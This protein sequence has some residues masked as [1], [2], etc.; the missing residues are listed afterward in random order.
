MDYRILGSLEVCDGDRSVALG[1]DKQRALLAILL[2][3][4]NEA[5]SADRLIDDLW[6]EGPPPTA[7]KTLQAY[8]S[9]LRKTLGDNGEPSSG[10]SHG[11]LVTRGHGYVL[12]IEP[13]EL[14]VDRFRG[15]VEKGRRALAAGEP[16]Q[17]AKILRQG[18]ALWRGPPLED[19]TYEAFAQA[20]IAHL[21]ELRL[22]AL[23]ERVEADLAL[24]RHDQLV[25]ELAALVERNPLRERVRG[26][27][28]LALYRCGRQAEALAVYQE[29]RQGLSE[30]LGL[31]RARGCVSSRPQSSTAIPRSTHRRR[32]GGLPTR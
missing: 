8:V 12:R 2:L 1:G 3:H 27:L 4:A 10:S 15:L 25:G 31:D 13:G 21:E 24:G 6:G 22:G 11:V 23:E 9:R 16:D 29:F 5:V 32:A 7:L 20:P 17:A 30:Q 14:D 19:F 28:M 18:L 26:Q